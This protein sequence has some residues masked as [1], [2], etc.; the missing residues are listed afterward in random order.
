[1]FWQIPEKESAFFVFKA[2]D[3]LSEKGEKLPFVQKNMET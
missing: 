1:M 3:Q 2:A